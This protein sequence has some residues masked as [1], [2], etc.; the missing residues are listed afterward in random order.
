MKFFVTSVRMLI[1]YS[2]W[3]LLVISIMQW[4]YLDIWYL[5][6]NTKIHF[7]WNRFIE[8]HMLSFC[9][10]STHFQ[11]WNSVLRSQIHKQNIETK[12][13]LLVYK[14]V[15]RGNIL[16]N[17][18]HNRIIT[19]VTCIYIFKN[20]NEY[21][22]SGWNRMTK[23]NNKLFSITIT[24]YIPFVLNVVSTFNFFKDIILIIVSQ[25]TRISL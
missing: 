10:R 23:I 6:P 11:V 24:T 3:K 9:S 21:H 7:R 22:L 2:W 13:F 12:Y 20:N 1:W 5:N 15:I 18:W 17:E 8:Y 16:K 14:I 19:D 25:T 4:V